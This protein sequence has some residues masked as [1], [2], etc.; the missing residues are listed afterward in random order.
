MLNPGESILIE[1]AENGV[2]VTPAVQVGKGDDADRINYS[3]MHVF[4][5]LNGLR[6]FLEKHFHF[7]KAE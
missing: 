5:G 7:G 6:E 4:E 3:K 2:M 1:Q